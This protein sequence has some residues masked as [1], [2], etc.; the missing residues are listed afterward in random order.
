VF[1]SEEYSNMIQ[2]NVI[3][4]SGYSSKKNEWQQCFKTNS[5]YLDC[6]VS[7]YLNEKNYTMTVAIQNPSSIDIN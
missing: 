7:N 2:D 1:N 5:T 6:P 4:F 3:N